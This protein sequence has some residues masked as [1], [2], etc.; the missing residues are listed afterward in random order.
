[1]MGETWTLQTHVGLELLHAD[2]SACNGYEGGAAAAA[3]IRCPVLV[4]SSLRDRMVPLQEVQ[5]L[6]DSIPGA[7]LEV[8]ERAGHQ[9]NIEYPWEVAKLIGD[10][11]TASPGS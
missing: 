1:M 4:I 3:A 5:A 11:V 8:L 7:R 2:L 9:Q 6:V 10:F